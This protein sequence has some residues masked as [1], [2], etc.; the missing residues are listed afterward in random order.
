MRLYVQS[1]HQSGLPNASGII[2][3]RLAFIHFQPVEKYPPAI[4]LLECLD[5]TT[6][7]T[8]VWTTELGATYNKFSLNNIRLIRLPGIQKE[9]HKIVRLFKYIHFSFSTLIYLLCYKPD[10]ILYFETLSGLPGLLYKSFF[11]KSVGLLVHY[12]EYTSPREYEE[13]MFMNK[14]IHSLERKFI[15]NYSWVSHT[16][17]KRAE[18]FKKDVSHQELYVDVL[19]NYPP[20][21]WM[22]QS[23]AT[24]NKVLNPIRLVYVGALCTETMYT[25]ELC[26]WVINQRGRVIL[27]FWS[28]NVSKNAE[29][30]FK[31][32]R[33]EWINMRGG[34]NYNE[35][36]SV[37]SHYDVG[38]ILY[39]GHISNYVYNAPNKLF[40]YLVCGL[41]VWFPTELKGSYPYIWES[42]RPK[43]IKLDFKALNL[44]TVEDIKNSNIIEFREIAFV[45]EEVYTKLI[46]NILTEPVIN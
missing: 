7:K 14:F 18:M 45:A 37:L 12:H 13:G 21:K 9:D 25:K 16:N 44:L 20:R 4:N 33:F 1:P 35:L 6:I 41:D 32:N 22:L 46:E 15:S 24:H 29:A 40:E 8:K 34:L 30:F 31:E 2:I 5:K 27:D 43:V 36:P 10:K 17:S 28:Q 3:L 11:F 42:S 23:K 39:K 26:D 19:P 38:V